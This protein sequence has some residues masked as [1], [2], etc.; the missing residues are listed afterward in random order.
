MLRN[1]SSPYSNHTHT[2]Q[3]NHHTMHN[4]HSHNSSSHSIV[5]STSFSKGQ[6]RLTAFNS[7]DFLDDIFALP[8]AGST[9]NNS[10]NNNSRSLFSNNGLGNQHNV[11]TNAMS[12]GALNP[13]PQHRGLSKKFSFLIPPPI[14]T[15]EVY[16]KSNMESFSPLSS[17]PT[18]SVRFEEVE[19]EEEQLA[20][21][22]AQK[23]AKEILSKCNPKPVVVVDLD[24]TVRLAS[25]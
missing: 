2:T 7:S 24:Y 20:L 1:K 16:S 17:L 14:Q 19:D 9:N 23:R 11:S 13:Q 10:N 22:K 4:G 6:Q 3:H 8:V 5:A 18:I 15:N 21:F 25:S 12:Q